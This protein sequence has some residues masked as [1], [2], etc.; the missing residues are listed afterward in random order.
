M[1]FE[2]E[3]DGR[4]F[5]RRLAQRSRCGAPWH[6]STK[7]GMAHCENVHGWRDHACLVQDRFTSGISLLHQA[8]NTETPTRPEGMDSS[9][10]GIKKICNNN[11][12]LVHVRYVKTTHA[13]ADLRI[14]RSGE[15][16]DYA[17]SFC[18]GLHRI[19]ILKSSSI[20]I[21]EIYF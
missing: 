18:F 21:M 9:I 4:R 13:C 8:G 17:S 1:I 14:V 11:L 2:Q 19:H 5:Q 20:Y 15:D 3:A 12:I 16:V 10:F 7:I 6:S